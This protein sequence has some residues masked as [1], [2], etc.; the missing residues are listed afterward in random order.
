MTV[1]RIG[2]YHNWVAIFLSLRLWMTCSYHHCKLGWTLMLLGHYLESFCQALLIEEELLGELAWWP[3]I[4]CSLQA[5]SGLETEAASKW[6]VSLRFWQLEIKKVHLLRTNHHCFNRVLLVRLHLL[7]SRDLHIQYNVV[8]WNLTSCIAQYIVFRNFKGT[9]YTK[10]NYSNWESNVTGW[11]DKETGSQ[12]SWI[13]FPAL[14][15]TH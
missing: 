10:C 6:I 5:I 1:V 4:P 15:L 9:A 13:L 8:C 12:D 11:L 7:Y 14:P 3:K 2:L